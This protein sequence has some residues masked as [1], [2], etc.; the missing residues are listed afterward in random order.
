[1]RWLKSGPAWFLAAILYVPAA[2]AAGGDRFVQKVRLA[3]GSFLAVAEGEF[4]PRST[5]SYTLRLYSGA[6]P[7]YPFDDFVCGLVRPR[8]GAIERLQQADVTGDH[9]PDLLVVIRSAGTGGYL[10]ADAWSVSAT[11]LSLVAHVEGLDGGAD[12]LSALR[13]ALLSRNHRVHC[14]R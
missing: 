13:N 7:A 10:A 3:S 9:V 14:G 2:V 8:D 11:T 5:G 4:E 12:P 6:M 1:M